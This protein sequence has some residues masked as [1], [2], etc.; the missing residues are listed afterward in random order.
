MIP[1]SKCCIDQFSVVLRRLAWSN[2][3][4]GHEGGSYVGALS[5]SQSLKLG[6]GCHMFLGGSGA[7]NLA[8]GELFANLFSDDT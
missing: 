3:P 6:E 2:C 1:F 5:C 4:G 7:E 8:Q